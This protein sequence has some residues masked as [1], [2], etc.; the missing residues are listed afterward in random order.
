MVDPFIFRHVLVTI[1][2]L[3]VAIQFSLSPAFGG[4]VGDEAG[5]RFCIPQ[6]R[7]PAKGLYWPLKPPAE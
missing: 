1:R 3:H 7:G 5:T 6:M 4:G 2:T